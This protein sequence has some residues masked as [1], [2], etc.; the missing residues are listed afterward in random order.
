MQ[1]GSKEA[2]GAWGSRLLLGF[3]LVCLLATRA[4][5]EKPV[6]PPGLDRDVFS[7]ANSCTASNCTT[8]QYFDDRGVCLECRVGF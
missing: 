8:G 4:E 1:M 7:L 2:T 3:W 6:T 5:G